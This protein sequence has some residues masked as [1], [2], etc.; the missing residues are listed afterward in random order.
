MQDNVERIKDEFIL[1]CSEV[2][3]TNLTSKLV[4]A[5]TLLPLALKVPGSNLL[6]EYY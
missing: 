3:L 2:L 6:P 1:V 4:Q 5:A